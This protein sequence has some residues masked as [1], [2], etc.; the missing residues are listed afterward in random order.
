MFHGSLH[1]SSKMLPVVL[2]LVN[3]MDNPVKIKKGQI[4]GQV[5]SVV[6]PSDK[7]SITDSIFTASP[8]R[9][10]HHTSNVDTIAV[11]PDKILNREEK[12]AFQN[13]NT[14]YNSVFNPQ[15]G[16]YNEKSGK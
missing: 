4:L 11:G 7:P 10:Q 3:D 15:F 5:R 12:L 6:L 13:V 2:V 14:Q 9:K 1:V 8:S 16:T